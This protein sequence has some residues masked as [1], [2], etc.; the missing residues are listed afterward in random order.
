MPACEKAEKIKITIFH[1][2]N[3]MW[4][5]S[6]ALLQNSNWTRP[7]CN[8]F[9]QVNKNKDKI[10]RSLLQKH[11]QI[12]VAKFYLSFSKS[13]VV[14]DHSFPQGTGQTNIC[15]IIDS[16]ECF[17]IHIYLNPGG[18]GVLPYMGYISNMC[19]PTGYGFS[20]V[21]VMNRV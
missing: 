5:V 8:D 15:F 10:C 2:E 7:F 18:R 4:T 9:Y 21:S 16:Q 6:P 1:R 19:S 14:W 13:H 12:S 3:I 11:L 17:T 20:A